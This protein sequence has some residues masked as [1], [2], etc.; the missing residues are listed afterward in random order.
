[1][2]I[3]GLDPSLSATGYAL[4]SGYVGTFTPKGRR[5]ERLGNAAQWIEEILHVHEI[6]VVY[7]EGYSYGSKG[8]AAISLGELGGVL[9]LAIADAGVKMVEV[10]PATLKKYAT[11]AG[12]AAKERVLV[13]AV[14]RLDYGG[15]STDE[16]DALWLY[17]L[18]ACIAGVRD[19]R[20]PKSHLNALKKIKAPK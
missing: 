18:G 12:N 1:M 5:V 14:K 15:H 16:A 13:A 2:N 7:L 9:R 10:S 19:H 11:G 4:P 8:R 20:V 6:D 17:E 3:L